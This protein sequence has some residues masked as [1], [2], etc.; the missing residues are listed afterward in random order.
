[1][2]TRLHTEGWCLVEFFKPADWIYRVHEKGGGGAFIRSGAFIR[3]NTVDQIQNGR[4][5]A[6][7]H[8]DRPDIGKTVLDS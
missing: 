6:N 5:S 4:L 8:L 3:D 2:L 1:M 7:V